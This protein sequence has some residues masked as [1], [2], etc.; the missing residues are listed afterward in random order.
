MNTLE[1]TAPEPTATAT[2]FDVAL[3]C[4]ADADVHHAL[5]RDDIEAFASA[6]DLDLLVDPADRKLLFAALGRAG[7]VAKVDRRLHRKWLFVRWIGDRFVA[8][9]VHAAFVQGGVEYMDAALALGRLDR[10]QAV[11]RLGAEDRFLHVFLHNLLGKPQLQAKHVALLR[12]LHAAGLDRAR[13][14]DQGRRFGLEAVAQAA[15]DDLENCIADAGAW[16]RLRTTARRALLRRPQSW[17]GALRHRHGDRLRPRFDRRPVVLALLGPDGSGK[18]SFADALQATLRDTPLRSGRVY[19]GCWGHDVL[20]MRHVRR[21]IPPQVSFMRLLLARC[22]LR[23]ALSPEETQRLAAAPSRHA[24]ASAALRYGIK[25]AVFHVLLVVELG[26]RFVRG[27][28]RSRRSIVISDRWVH[29]LEF[30]QGKVPFVHGQV[31][32]RLFYALFP[33]PD[34]I[35]YLTT[36]YD[37]VEKRKP[38][39]DRT[40]FETMDAV[41]RRVLA[42]QRPLLVTSDASPAELVHRFLTQHWET[43]VD[44]CNRRA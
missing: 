35:L 44:H 26:W 11:P 39:L 42:R 2:P 20:P 8:L 22:G 23:P 41:F 36:P 34:G 43:L 37:L 21:L 15:C 30:R 28:R 32:R 31:W 25:G 29:D 13:I 16:S 4:L 10:S 17:V 33:A 3:A 12:R 9:D 40:Q 14:L 6:R 5:L 7:F 27:I 18:T 38:Q 19:M 24:L 1:L